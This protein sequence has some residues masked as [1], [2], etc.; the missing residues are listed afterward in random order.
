M[1]DSERDLA[2]RAQTISTFQE[3]LQAIAPHTTYSLPDLTSHI[4]HAGKYTRPNIKLGS[5]LFLSPDAS[6]DS[7]SNRPAKADAFS[8]LTQPGHRLSREKSHNEV[9]FG[10][11]LLHWHSDSLGYAES[12]VAIKPTKNRAAILGELAMFQYLKQKNLPTFD[13]TGILLSPSGHSDHLLTKFEKPVA[14]MDTVEWRDLETQEKWLQVDFAVQTMALL[15]SELLF[16]GDLEFKNVGFGDRGDLIIVDPELTVSSLEMAD[17]AQSSSNEKEIELAQLRIKQSMS[18]DFTSVCLSIDEFII[19]SLPGDERPLTSASKFKSYARYL[20]RPYREALIEAGSPYLPQ[21]LIAY[22][23][24][25]QEH[26]QRSR[27]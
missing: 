21:L 22:E 27:E 6:G 11:L 1:A 9:F 16:H 13:P 3:D 2:L 15:H 8:F 23:K 20:F 24:V 18:T 26:K 10:K 17:I 19:S 7:E 25:F 4:N 5:G 12:Q 14:T